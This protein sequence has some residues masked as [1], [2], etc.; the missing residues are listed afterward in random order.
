MTY[1]LYCRAGVNVVGS[2]YFAVSLIVTFTF[3]VSVHMGA[4]PFLHPPSP[5]FCLLF[6]WIALRVLGTPTCS[7]IHIEFCFNYCYA[8]HPTMCSF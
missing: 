3:Q 4:V 7:S 2:F 1:C 8:S 5:T 6:V